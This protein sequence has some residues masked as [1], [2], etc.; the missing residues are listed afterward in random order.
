M[1]LYRV[2]YSVL[3]DLNAAKN[4]LDNIR[5][6]TMYFFFIYLREENQLIF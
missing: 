5:Y 1:E 6:K 4:I 2:Y 3:L